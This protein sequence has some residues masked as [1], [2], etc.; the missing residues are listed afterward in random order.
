M[1]STTTD[2]VSL[3]FREEVTA[4]LAAS[5]MSKTA[6][7]KAALNDPAFIDGMNDGRDLRLS[8]LRRVREFMEKNPSA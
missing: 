4:Y 2:P 1:S 5:G 6:F 3:A 7:G 8:T